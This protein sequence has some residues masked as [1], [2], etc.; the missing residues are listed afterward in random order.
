MTP[1]LVANVLRVSR[2]GHGLKFAGLLL[3]AR[4]RSAQ[5]ARV[6]LEQVERA[7]A[8]NGNEALAACQ[9]RT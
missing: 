9:A 4:R 6:L 5:Q 3:S 1:N 7:M 2:R 8:A